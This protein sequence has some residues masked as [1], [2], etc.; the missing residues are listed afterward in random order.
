MSLRRKRPLLVRRCFIKSNS[1]SYG[2]FVG[3]PN[4]P[5]S[6]PLLP[7]LLFDSPDISL[8][9]W[10]NYLD[11]PESEET[12]QTL[13]D[14]VELCY[15]FIIAIRRSLCLVCLILSL[16]LDGPRITSRGLILSR[17]R[18][19]ISL[20]L[21]H[22]SSAHPL[23]IHQMVESQGDIQTTTPVDDKRPSK[24]KRASLPQSM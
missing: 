8:S 6:S 7:S 9:L 19:R 20:T 12:I 16:R 22:S 1:I 21:A 18:Y 23:L 3:S 4:T 13:F 14:N 15:A 24:R 11:C 17:K 10:N 5:L 2:L